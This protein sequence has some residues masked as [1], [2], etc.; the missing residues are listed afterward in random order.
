MMIIFQCF[1]NPNF[2]VYFID[3][4]LNFPSSRPANLFFLLMF[5]CLVLNYKEKK[6]EKK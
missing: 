2:V 4:N 5:M 1:T 6:N 3:L